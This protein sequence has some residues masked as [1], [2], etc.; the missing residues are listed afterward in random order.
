MW[1]LWCSIVRIW[2]KILL[3]S[4]GVQPSGV[5]TPNWKKMTCLGSHIKHIETCR[6]K[7]FHNVL[8]KFMILCWAAF[9][10][11]LS[12][13]PLRANPYMQDKVIFTT[14]YVGLRW[15][16]LDKS[17]IFIFKIFKSVLF[18]PIYHRFS[19]FFTSFLKLFLGACY[20]PIPLIMSQVTK[21]TIRF[22]YWKLFMDAK[23]F[24]LFLW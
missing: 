11:I 20:M 4:R 8:S 12:W 24:F 23:S 21:N 3:L 18:V 16:I 17:E 5:S 1:T 13:T 15:N 22:L 10:A 14:L 6:H 2:V 7:K 19:S 9:T